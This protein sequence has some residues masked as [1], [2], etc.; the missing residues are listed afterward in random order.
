MKLARQVCP[1]DRV[2]FAFFSPFRQRFDQWGCFPASR[3]DSYIAVDV[4]EGYSFARLKCERR[5]FDVG[6]IKQR[7]ERRD[8]HG[9][10]VENERYPAI[11]GAT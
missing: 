4:F 9:T 5:G 6:D 7:P 10:F 1:D 11:F 2:E 3:P 8:G